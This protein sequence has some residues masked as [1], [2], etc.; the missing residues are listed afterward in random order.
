MFGLVVW[1]LSRNK[2]VVLSFFLLRILSSVDMVNFI[3]KLDLD[4]YV[5]LKVVNGKVRQFYFFIY[6]WFN[7]GVFVVMWGIFRLSFM[8]KVEEM[9]F[10]DLC[11][12]L[13]EVEG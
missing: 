8:V 11:F 4:G 3:V 5:V 12:I 6:K 7:K 10:S 13:F 2:E 1:S 9:I